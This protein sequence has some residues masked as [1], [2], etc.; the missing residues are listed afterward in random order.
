MKIVKYLICTLF[1]V[2]MVG[3]LLKEDTYAKE[4]SK[5]GFTYDDEVYRATWSEKKKMEVNQTVSSTST[6]FS[7][8]CKLGIV[9]VYSGMLT[10]KK[11]ING[12]LH[13]SV[14]ISA[15]MIPQEH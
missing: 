11:R 2:F 15:K 14:L 5:Y 4:V 10:S 6:K 12:D 13:Q 9:E 3:F 1:I 7:K 8:G